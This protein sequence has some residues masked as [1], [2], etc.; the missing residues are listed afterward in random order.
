M[1]LR[2]GIVFLLLIGCGAPEEATTHTDPDPV[3]TRVRDAGPM[4]TGPTTGG[5]GGA[6]VGAGGTGGSVMPS[7]PPIVSPPPGKADGGAAPPPAGKQDGGG[8]VDSSPPATGGSGG[9]Q[10][11]PPGGS[12]GVPS[13]AGTILF[14]TPTFALESINASTWVSTPLCNGSPLPY[15]DLRVRWTDGSKGE[16]VG[17]A[18]H[19]TGPTIVNLA[20]CQARTN[21]YTGVY[22][23]GGAAA[24]SGGWALIAGAMNPTA[25]T[26]N[27]HEIFL[28]SVKVT[29]YTPGTQV[30]D[31]DVGGQT[32]CY[33]LGTDRVV[34][35]NILTMSSTRTIA[36]KGIGA[37]MAL[38]DVSVDGSKVAFGPGLQIVSSSVGG[39]PLKFPG[40]V[41]SAGAQGRAVLSPNG[42]QVAVTCNNAGSYILNVFATK[43]GSRLLSK[44]WRAGTLTDWQW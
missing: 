3:S 21:S 41:C 37:P 40:P 7:P 23:V 32:V 14:V 30:T 17:V 22:A 34:C 16:V 35:D 39:T 27:V 33:T 24:Y 8:A 28:N 6:S 1:R 42:A 43:D 44:P 2:L 13:L 18:P 20:S 5:T 11:P 36:V 38:H 4:V 10:D 9:S 19:S 29:D 15:G 31:M 12:G 26:P 25:A